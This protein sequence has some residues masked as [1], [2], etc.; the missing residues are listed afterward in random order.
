MSAHG[1]VASLA[2]TLALRTGPLSWT[3]R[4]IRRRP[5]AAIAGVALLVA[6]PLATHAYRTEHSILRA[7][8][9]GELADRLANAA[10]FKIATLS[11]TGR[12]QLTEAEILETAGITA[13]TSLLLLD[14][15]AVRERLEANPWIAEATVRKLYPDHLEIA[16]VERR[17]F[18][19]WQKDYTLSLISPDGTVLAPV[20]PRAVPPLPLVVGPGAAAK[21]QEFLSLLD[22]YPVLR[23]ELRAAIRVADRRWNLKLKSG[24]DIRLPESGVEAA[25]DRL[26]ALDHD[27]KIL[28]RDLTAIDLR[29]PDRVTVRLSEE[30]AQ[31]RE[32]ALKDKKK[33]KGGGDA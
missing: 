12:Q 6:A 2:R 14:V 7:G 17:A 24:L 26:M 13:N 19:V 22:H 3:F 8:L 11:I 25:L 4:L 21:A 32:Q 27:K 15:V 30:A 9:V 28:T 10:G 29:L 16:L 23:D 5:R 18:A 20:D 33:R 31:A 1:R